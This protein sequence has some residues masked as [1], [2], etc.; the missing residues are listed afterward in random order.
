[1]RTCLLVMLQVPSRARCLA[2]G[3]PAPPAPAPAEVSP[4]VEAEAGSPDH[5]APEETASLVPWDLEVHHHTSLVS[6]VP[7]GS[8]NGRE[9][10]NYFYFSN[11]SLTK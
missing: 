11:I 9:T 2:R 5:P 8:V 7:S 4:W 3:R 6:P 10:L 1:M